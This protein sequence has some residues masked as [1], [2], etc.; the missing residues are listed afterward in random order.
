MNK[1][2]SVHSE[3]VGFGSGSRLAAGFHAVLMKV[4]VQQTAVILKPQA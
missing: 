3:R 4:S 2:V 1:Q